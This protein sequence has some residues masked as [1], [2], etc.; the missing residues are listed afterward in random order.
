MALEFLRELAEQSLPLTLRDP[1]RVEQVRFLRRAECVAAFI[2]TIGSDQPFATVLCVT[3]LGREAL[4][5]AAEEERKAK[6]FRPS[7]KP[8][9]TRSR[10]NRPQKPMAAW[11]SV[12]PPLE[13]SLGDTAGGARA[14][15][16][17]S[18]PRS[19]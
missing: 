11:Q 17:S 16:Q 4:K 15:A 13:N 18:Y 10:R 9:L 2:S 8:T 3:K 19:L 7:R 6:A 5:Q 12:P 1:V 14:Q